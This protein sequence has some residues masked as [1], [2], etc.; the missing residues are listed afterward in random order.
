MKDQ[1]DDHIF[2]QALLQ[3]FPSKMIMVLQ[4]T[5]EATPAFMQS[6]QPRRVPKPCTCLQ[7]KGSIYRAVFG[8]GVWPATSTRRSR[9]RFSAGE[10]FS[11]VFSSDKNS[12]DWNK[13][14]LGEEKM[15]WVFF[16][17][18][19][20]SQ[21]RLKFSPGLWLW[22]VQSDRRNKSCSWLTTKRRR[23]WWLIFHTDLLLAWVFPLG[24]PH[25]SGPECPCEDSVNLGEC[26]SRWGA[27]DL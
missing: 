7:V 4:S 3:N 9:V 20:I 22:V 13:H 17:E 14:S 2:V 19:K 16:L 23:H 15:P 11:D 21:H 10:F 1:E 26:G 25:A 8:S 18:G 5:M 6:T 12:L 24:F 27:W